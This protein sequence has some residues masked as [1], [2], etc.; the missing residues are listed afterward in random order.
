MSKNVDLFGHD[1][2]DSNAISGKYHL[3]KDKEAYHI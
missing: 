2:R 3:L 1:E